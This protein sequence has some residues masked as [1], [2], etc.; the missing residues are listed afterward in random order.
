MVSM[1]TIISCMDKDRRPVQRVTKIVSS[2]QSNYLR[3][4]SI[5]NAAT[6]DL[7]I[8]TNSK[9]QVSALDRTDVGGISQ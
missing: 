5:I 7:S 9:D 2:T 6:G 8:D 3:D 4:Q 1:Q